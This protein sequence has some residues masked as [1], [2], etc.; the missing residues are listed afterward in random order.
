MMFMLPELDRV[1]LRQAKLVKNLLVSKKITISL[2]ESCTGGQLSSVLTNIP[3]ISKVM[4]GSV[5]VYSAF[6]KSELVGVS[7]IT[8]SDYGT[9]S[10]QT[11]YELAY[12]IKNISNT[13]IGI[14]VV[15]VLGPFPDE[16]RNNVGTMYIGISDECST[17][18]KFFKVDACCRIKMK[19]LVVL[20]I[21]KILEG[22]VNNETVCGSG[23]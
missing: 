6:Y 20:K 22:V 3:G 4:V 21:L 19:K 9:V 17:S 18:V 13:S 23:S 5:V 14:S 12:N 10:F 15:C 16:K 2:A 8:I 7:P 1:L 11:A